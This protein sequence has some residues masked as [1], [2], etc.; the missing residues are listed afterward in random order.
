MPVRIAFYAPM[1][2]PDYPTRSGDRRIARLILDALSAAGHEVDVASR[3]RSRDG[4]GDTRRQ[5]RIRDLGTRLAERLLRRY[6]ASNI[7]VY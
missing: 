7:L 2:A 4:A 5:E 1:K 3:F 6:G